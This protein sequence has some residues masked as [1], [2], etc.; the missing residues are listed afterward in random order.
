MKM[1]TFG[2]NITHTVDIKFIHGYSNLPDNLNS[3]EIS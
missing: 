1:D 3:F 2:I